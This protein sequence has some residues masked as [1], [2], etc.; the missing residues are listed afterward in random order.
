MQQWLTGFAYRATMQW[1]VVAIAGIVAILIA[2]ATVSFQS[3]KAALANPVKAL[4]SE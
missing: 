2:F 3:I 4:K 1:W